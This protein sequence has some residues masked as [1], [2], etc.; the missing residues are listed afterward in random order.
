MVKITLT[1]PDG[2]KKQYDK[3]VTPLK[4]AES[5]GPRLAQAALAAKVD[6][7]NV[8]LYYKI[9]KDAKFRIFTFK[10]PEGK[11]VFRHS[12]AHI[13]AYAV[14]ELFP[15]AK[16]TIG[17]A[18]DEGFYYDFD[19][20]SITP[21]DFEKIEKK[22]QEII[23]KDIKTEK[24]VLT[25]K[26][27]E[28]TFAGNPY[29]IEMAKEF[30]K[31]GQELTAYKMGAGFIDLC[32]GPHTISTGIIKA[33]KLIKIAGA[34]WR[35]DKKN[36][37]LTRV[38]G[39]SFP[40]EKE[41]KD[42]LTMQEEASKRDHRKIG[43]EQDLFMFHEFS[44]GSAFFMPKGTVIYNELLSFIRAEYFKR[45]YKEVITP[46]LYNKALWE[47]SGHWQHYKENMFLMKVDD[48]DFSLKPMNCP[49]H[50]LMYK[51]SSHSYRDL[52]LRIAD[53]CPLHRNELR[54]VIGG[55]TRVRKMSQDDGHI[56]CTQEQISGEIKSLLE[57]IKY[58][59]VDV[60]KMP[61]SARI[62]TRPEKAMGDEKLW[63]N[64]EDIL[65]DCCK[66]AKMNYSI[67]SGEG[68][69]YGPK[70]DF[71]VKDSLGREWQLA[72]IQLDFQM[73]LKMGAEYEGADNKKHTVT[74]IH[75]AVFGSLE[76]FIGVL[77]EHYA[78]KFP[79]WLSPVQARILTIADRFNPYAEKVSEQLKS[80]GIRVE[81][82]FMPET[83]NK[84]IRNAQIEQVNYI[85]VVG[86]RE[87][88]DGT[89][90]VRTRDNV[91]H[92]AKK[93]D[94]LIK[95]LQQEVAGKK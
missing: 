18:V 54:G 32:E 22:M 93:V 80:A 75:R 37:Q 95:Q 78:G 55:L 15:K 66:K 94:A 21:A 51:N 89:V 14:Q 77:V 85:L 25:L 29:K 52:P 60:F 26:D 9:E 39:I 91:D 87:T 58:V 63:K 1:F 7:K 13:F 40:S 44:P 79:L 64:A 43:R 36:K 16:N 27:V 49:S 46:Q 90:A 28:K 69:F 70:V 57:F 3:G 47:L 34:Y 42:Y 11:E 67:A 71:M 33:V 73:P 17:P 92:G 23:K 81:T 12:T 2:S 74:M 45:G 76:R 61:Y 41:L 83:L 38:Y 48:E 68:A 20:L 4:V 19:D 10:D 86:E 88:K 31:Q 84:K 82:D 30:K 50:V 65:E 62:G 6:D 8:D 56:F 24:V 72:T 35:G 53:F 59:Y 5:I